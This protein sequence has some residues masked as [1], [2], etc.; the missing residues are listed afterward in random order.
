MTHYFKIV[1]AMVIWSTW[2]MMIRWLDLPAAVVLFYTSL[3]ASLSV[4][5]VLHVRGEL[6]LSGVAAVPGLFAALAIS[7]IINNVT[8]FYAL[9]ATTISNAVFTHY[10]AP[11]FVAVLA[12][13]IIGERVQRTT[14]VSLPLALSGMALIVLGG[15]GLVLGGAHAAGILAGTASGIAYAVLIIISRRLSQ[16]MMHHKAVVLLLWI[17]T[18]ATAPVAFL[19]PHT[20][21]GRSLALLLVTGIAH[22]TLA[23]L[24]YYSALRHVIAQN[25][26]ILGY[27]E[28]LAAVPLAFLFLSERPALLAVGGG[29]LILLSGFL[30]V[31]SAVRP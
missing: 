24:L 4:P 22:S 27:I 8:Y 15:G 25:A 28:P 26:A 3:I 6:D 2:G 10:T 5:A 1:V 7:S 30:V 23:P 19:Q 13:I 9:G 17:T 20:L 12:P 18:V 16:L 29:A 11:V 14:L 21:T 31:R